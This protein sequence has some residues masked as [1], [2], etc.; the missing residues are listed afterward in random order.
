MSSCKIF[1]TQSNYIPW[2][3]YFDAINEADF[4]VVYDHVQ[5]TKN[6]WRNRNK[7]KREN[8]ADWLTIPARFLNLNQKINEVEVAT[9]DWAIKHWKTLSLVYAKAPYFKTYKPIFEELYSTIQT[10]N[11]SEINQLFI[12]A[13]C[14][15]LS[16]D[17]KILLSTELDLSEPDRVLKLVSICK[18]LGGTEYLSGPAGKN[19]IDEKTF[20]DNNLTIKWLDYSS[21]QEYNQMH[22]PFEHGVSIIDLI[23]NEGENARNF[24]KS[25]NSK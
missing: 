10:K 20:N 9:N 12:K 15:I 6:D 16:I 1:I 11:L 22:P 18:Q 23:F 4:F 8:G 21:Y 2:K 7:I 19:Y 14:K 24:M 25:F 13:I 5:Y 17:T 3:G